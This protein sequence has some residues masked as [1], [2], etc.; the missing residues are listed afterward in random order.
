MRL[1][2]A[3]PLPN[4]IRRRL[5]FLAFSLSAALPAAAQEAPAT[6]PPESERKLVIHGYLSQAFAVS[7]GYQVLGISSDGTFDYRTAALQF[8]AT[9]TPRDSFVIQ[10]SQERLGESPVMQVRNE[11]DLDWIFYERELGAGI[12]L[13]VGKIRTPFG[14]YNEIRF[15]GPLLPFFRPPDV[16]YGE[17]S[18]VSSSISGA[19]LSK[20]LFAAHQFSLDADVYGG[21]WS[22]LQADRAT[23]AKAKKGLGGQLWLNTPREGLRLGL[24]AHRSTWSNSLETPPGSRVQ[25]KRWAASV[26]GNFKRFRLNAEFEKDTFPGVAVNA[27]YALVSLHVTDKL[28]LNLLASQSHLKLELA[29]FD[30]QRGR[31]YAAGV[32]YKFRPDLVAKVESH[33]PEGRDFEEPGATIFAP[34]LKAN[35]LIVSLSA[36]F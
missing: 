18:Y 3:R 24:A 12:R 22:F 33:W 4:G 27:V 21:E 35:Y 16:F 31:D 2:P 26:D 7:D 1:I 19:A 9:I 36:L 25:H 32:S 15:V 10:F 23:R 8:R 34:P 20:S 14:I 6:P 17:G 28:S 29:R 30:E 13:R 5:L 11:I